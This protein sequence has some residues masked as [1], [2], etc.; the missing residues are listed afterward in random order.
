MAILMRPETGEILAMAAVP[1]FNPNRY[2][3]SPAGHWRN[4]AVTDVF[5][6]G[7]TFKV[8]TAAAAVEEGVVSE[9]ERIDCGQGS[10]QVGSQVIRD[11]KVFDVLTFREVMQFS[12]NVGMIRIS[13]RL[14]KERMEQYVHAFGFGEPT[15][16]NLPAESRGILRPAAGWSSRTLASIAFGQEIGVTPLQMVTAVNA[17]AASGYLMRPQ[18]VREIRAPSGELFSKFEPEPVRRVVSRET[19][20]RLTEIL[21][22]VVDGG[23]GTRAA[24]AGYTVAGKTGT[25]QKASPSGGYSKTD[26]IASFVGFV[27]AYR[28]EITALI[29]LDSPTGDHTGARAASVFAEIVEPSL[30]YLGVPPELD[31]GVSSVIARWPRQKTLAS[32]LSSGHQEWSSV[33]PAVAG[34]SIPGGIRVPA[35][36]GLPARDAVARAIGMRL[37]PK[38]LGSGWVVGQEPPAGRLVGPGTRFLLI[39]GPS[40]ATGF[41]DAVRIADDTRRGGQSPVPQRPRE[42]PAHSEA[43]F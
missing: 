26:Y 9:E 5:E 38:L 19:A 24:V 25:A 28:P 40:G 8:I 34:P 16:V 6:P 36:Y 15:E 20:A 1:F 14:G 31:S 17:I 13:Q 41:E 2:Q 11:H 3:D 21:V 10:I 43:S 22:G 30:H 4:R 42:T 35:L 32:E 23:T 29:L 12:S 33:T 7:S 37:A 39:L 27:P 18:L